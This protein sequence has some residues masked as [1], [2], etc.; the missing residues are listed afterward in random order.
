MAVTPYGNPNIV[1][2]IGLASDAFHGA[3][4]HSFKSS[5]ALTGGTRIEK[6]LAA[7]GAVAGTHWGRLFYKVQKPAPIG[8]NGAYYHVTFLALGPAA[9]GGSDESR[10]VDTVE[11]PSGKI[12]YLYNLPD[13]SCCNGSSYDWSFDGAWHCAEWYIDAGAKAYR[14]FIDSKEVTQLAFTGKVGARI[15]AAYGHV[16]LGQTFYV[17]P[18]GA[19]TSWVDDLAINDSQIGCN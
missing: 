12:Q 3:S 19:I 4:G 5:T 13:D 16:S 2:T 8:A 17:K 15:P 18:T 1:G 9:N 7:L 11:D 6:S 10:V 14:F